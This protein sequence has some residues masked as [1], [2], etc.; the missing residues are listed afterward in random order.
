MTNTS[1]IDVSAQFGGRDAAESV[2]PVYRA[3]KAA[4]RDITFQGFP[5]PKLA[6]VLRVDG[7]V[8]EYGLSGVG[9]VEF[10]K[11]G[12]YV[13]VD[14]GIT[15][16]DRGRLLDGAGGGVVLAAL[17]STVDSLKGLG[18]NELA[19]ADFG[20]LDRALSLFRQRYE[21]GIA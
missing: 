14:I 11:N 12:G 6:F 4:A 2:L 1:V 5:F 19:E 3:L 15:V 18:G 21:E 17:A 10:D 20:A 7:E 16:D 8:N 13:S 9:D